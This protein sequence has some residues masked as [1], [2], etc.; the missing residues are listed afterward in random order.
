MKPITLLA[1]IVSGLALGVPSSSILAQ[2]PLPLGETSEGR[3]MGSG[4]A[5]YTFE[6]PG[7]GF[8][9]VVVRAQDDVILTIMD[10]E[11]Q[12]L[13]GAQSDQDLGGDP[14][15]EQL[16]VVV[17]AAGSYRVMVE[18]FGSSAAGFHIG[19]T[20]MASALMEAPVDPD[21]KPSGAV[22]LEAGSMNDAS[23]DPMQGDRWDWFAITADQAGVMTILTR[24]EDEGDLRLEV[25]RSDDFR[26]PIDSSDQDMDGILGNES[27]TVGVTAGETIYARVSPAFGDGSPMTYQVGSGL[28]PG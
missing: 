1:A 17:P 12:P 9:T 15:A 18:P 13:P 5:E 27:V 10:D 20:F 6:A 21:G 2:S 3:L 8:L 14:G 11:F 26:M 16:V 25:F 24:T 19:G 28:I 7:A 4:G 22:Q 23:L